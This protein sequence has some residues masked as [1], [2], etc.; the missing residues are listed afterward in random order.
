MNYIYPV[1]FIEIA[2]DGEL[3]ATEL[4]GLASWTLNDQF[5]VDGL[6]TAFMDLTQYSFDGW[7]SLK[8]TPPT[9]RNPQ[10]ISLAGGTLKSAD[11]KS[12]ITLTTANAASNN[13]EGVSWEQSGTYVLN[14]ILASGVTFSINVSTTYS[15]KP[16]GKSGSEKT[17][18]SFKDTKNSSN[19]SDDISISYAKTA[20]WSEGASFSRASGNENYSYIG[21]KISISLSDTWL[22][23]L[24]FSNSATVSG[25][26]TYGPTN[27]SI[28]DDNSGILISFSV[29]SNT[30]QVAGSSGE[31]VKFTNLVIEDQKTKITTPSVDW[32]FSY[33][34][35][36]ADVSLIGTDGPGVTAEQLLPFVLE[37]ASD[38]P[39]SIILKQAS[40]AAASAG[41]DSVTGSNFDDSIDGGAGADSINAGT[42]DDRIYAGLGDTID[43]GSGTDT[44]DFS[45]LVDANG[46]P[47]SYNLFNRNGVYTV[48][49]TPT[50]LV[51]TDLASKQ[52][53]NFN[54]VENFIFNG[55][56][57]PA[58]NLLAPRSRNVSG[59]ELLW[60][61]SADD[62]NVD[63]ELPLEM[64][65]DFVLQN[66]PLT[67]YVDLSFFKSD[68][69]SSSK[70]PLYDPDKGTYSFSFTSSAAN[71][72]VSTFTYAETNVPESGTG[73]SLTTA[74]G[75]SNATKGITFSGSQKYAETRTTNNNSGTYNSGVNLGYTNT[76]GT[77]RDTTDD[78]ALTFKFSET[79]A[80]SA[81]SAGYKQQGTG[82][83]NIGLVQGFGL[84]MT[85]DGLVSYNEAGTDFTDNK[86]VAFTTT[87][88]N[89]TLSYKDPV[90]TQTSDNFTINFAGKIVYD[91][92][93]TQA[94]PGP[95]QIAT[96]TNI[97]TENFYGKLTTAKAV[98]DLAEYIDP[99]DPGRGAIF[100]LIQSSSGKVDIDLIDNVASYL[101][102]L[103]D[104][105][106]SAD[107]ILDAANALTIKQVD[108]EI[109]YL[110]AGADTVTGSVGND[111]IDGGS[112][113]DSI[114]AGK[115]DDLIYAGLRDVIDGGEGIDTV[116]LSTLINDKGGNYDYFDRS[117]NSGYTV[118]GTTS[119]LVFRDT[120]TGA[121]VKFNNVEQ[122]KF[123]DQTFSA[124]RMLTP[125]SIDIT[126][127]V[128]LRG[129]G[130]KVDPQDNLA[131]RAL[132]QGTE[133]FLSDFDGN[134]WPLHGTVDLSFFDKDNFSA[135]QNYNPDQGTF[136]FNF[137][138]T[139]ANGTASVFK[140]TET[141]A[142]NTA[143]GGSRTT[144][145][146]LS[147]AAA[148]ITFKGALN[149]SERYSTS[150]EVTTWN[151]KSTDWGFTYTNTQGTTDKLDDITSSFKF[152]IA[153]TGSE[154][155]PSPFFTETGTF[156]ANYSKA[157]LTLAASGTFINSE[158][159]TSGVRVE[160]NTLTFD[161][162]SLAYKN[163][164]SSQTEAN[165]SISF[166]GSIAYDNNGKTEPDQKIET[167][168]FT[169]K[170]FVAED[171]NGK[172]TTA[173]AK[174]DLSSEKYLSADYSL[175]FHNNQGQV[176]ESVVL[177]LTTMLGLEDN[178]DGSSAFDSILDAANAITLKRSG[179]TY[180]GSGSDTVTG[181]DKADT[182]DGGAGA[183]T[184]NMGA[185]DDLIYA[186]LGD[187]IDGGAG[188]DSVDFSRLLDA[189]GKALTYDL[190]NRNGVYTVSGTPTAL[191][192][193]DVASKQTI[194]VKNVEKF[195][196]GGVEVPADEFFAPNSQERSGNELLRGI[197][198][199]NPN[200]APD[201]AL[202]LGYRYVLSPQRVPFTNEID[203]SFFE[204]VDFIGKN[205][206]KTYDPDKGT[207]NFT[208]TNGSGSNLSTF[209]FAETTVPN[210]G[211]G[212]SRT[213]TYGLSNAAEGIT[214]TGSQGSVDTFRINNGIYSGTYKID[215]GFSFTDT[216]GTT[217]TTSDDLIIGFK[218]NDTG[219]WTS[220]AT[221][222][223]QEGT[224]SWTTNYA[225]Q[226][227]TLASS[228]TYIER[229][230]TAS[231]GPTGEKLTYTVTSTYT[232]YKLA[233]TNPD[234][235]KTADNFS[236]G[237]SGSLAYDL[238]GT[239]LDK[240][241]TGPRQIFTITNYTGE[242]AF[243]KL[244]TAKAELDLSK[245]IDPTTPNLPV[246]LKLHQSSAGKVD[247]E[248][249]GQVVSF[250][251]FFNDGETSTD[252]IW[253]AANVLTLKQGTYASTGAKADTITGSAGND[254][255]DGGTGADS[256]T[257]G[258]GDDLIYAGLG[259][260]IDG[261]LGTDT[262][263]LSTLGKYDF[264]NRSTS[265]G[266][267][268]TGTAA[269]LVFRD[270]GTNE[271]VK[272]NNVEQFK[273]GDETFLA[274]RMLDP[275]TIDVSGDQ[276]L[277][278]IGTTIEGL[279]PKSPLA[280]GI[281]YV[282]T[283][284]DN[285]MWPLYGEA[286]LQYFKNAKF[287]ALQNYD[288]DAGTFNFSFKS[289]ADVDK[290]SVFKF[291]E[292]AAART[293]TRES[294]A[295]T[296]QL[297]NSDL[298][299]SFKG[300]RSFTDSYSV[301]NGV[302]TGSTKRD[303]SFSY[304][305]TQATKVTTDDVTA[306]FKISVT[307]T[308][309]DKPGNEFYTNNGSFSVGYSNGKTGW[310]LVS[311]GTFIDSETLI[312]D[313]TRNTQVTN[314]TSY[315]LTYKNPD[316]KNTVDNATISF[317]GVVSADYDGSAKT[318]TFTVK[319]FKGDFDGGTITTAL[320]KIDISAA[321]YLGDDVVLRLF[322]SEDGKVD[323]SVGLYLS[324]LLGLEDN[325]DGPMADDSIVDYANAVTFKRSGEAHLGAG[326][327]TL[328]GSSGA[329]TVDGGTGADILTMGA[330]DDLIYAGLSD[331][332]DG[333][334]GNDTADL[335]RLLDTNGQP[336]P[337]SLYDRVNKYT[338]S[339]TPTALV[340]TDI[341]S[342]Q[343]IKFK[344]V[345]N[346][347]LKEGTFTAQQL[348]SPYTVSGDDLLWGIGADNPNLDKFSYL[349]MGLE[350]I[351]HEADTKEPVYPFYGDIDLGFFRGD[352]FTQTVFYNPDEGAHNFSFTSSAAN[353]S[354]STFTFKETT[355]PNLGIGGGQ[356][357][358][359]G[360][361][362][363]KA[364]INFT[365]STTGS[366]T[367]TA[368]NGGKSVVNKGEIT[369]TYSNTQGNASKA[370]DIAVSF[371]IG[372]SGTET[373]TASGYREL[374]NGN[375][376]VN[377]ANSGWSIVA[378]GTFTDTETRDTDRTVTADKSLVTITNY[379]FS[380]TNP[381]VGST[382]KDNFNISF[383]G[384]IAEDYIGTGTASSP[385]PTQILTLTNLS[386]DFAEASITTA[387]AVL[388]LSDRFEDALIVKT[389]SNNEGQVD[390][391][392]VNYLSSL[393]GLDN[394]ADGDDPNDS[395][396]DFANVVT[397][398]IAGSGHLGAGNDTVNGSAGNDEIDG[399][400]DADSIMAG[401]GDD[402]IYAGLGDFID[403]G[404][405][406]DTVDLSTLS[407][408]VDGTYDFFTRNSE[409]GYT[410]AGT[411]SALVFRDT[412]TGATVKFNN[413]EQFKLGEKTFS[414]GRM[415]DPS[416]FDISASNLL[417][418]TLSI[419][420]HPR[421][422]V[423][424]RG[425][426]TGV[427][428]LLD[429]IS[430]LTA[431]VDLDSFLQ[432]DFAETVNYN[433]ASGTYAFKFTSVPV[434]NK[435]LTFKF[436]ETSTAYSEKGGSRTTTYDLNN[437]A[438]GIKFTG[439]A[440]YA[441]TFTATSSNWAGSK[442][443]TYTDTQTTSATTDDV[444][445]SFKFTESGTAG[446]GRFQD[447]GT[448]AVS[449]ANGGMALASSGSFAG[450]GTFG[451]D[452]QP[453]ARVDTITLGN[454]SLSQNIS[455]R[456]DNFTLSFSGSIAYD[457]LG[458]SLDP[459]ATDPRMVFTVS[460]MV[461]EDQSSKITTASAKLDLSSSI[462]DPT[463]AA[464][465]VLIKL[466]QNDA[467]S[468]DQS[469]LENIG[470]IFG[471]DNDGSS[472]FD[473]IWDAANGYTI[474]VSGSV[475]S[476]GGNDTIT[477]SSGTDS[478]DA[479]SGADLVN[480]GTGDD[481]IFGGDGADVLNGE[482][483]EDVID[484]GMGADNI[485]GGTGNDS[486]MGGLG[487]DTI[488]GGD[489]DDGISGG[490]GDVI[491]GGSGNDTWV[492]DYEEIGSITAVTGSMAAIT[493]TGK[494]ADTAASNFTIT[495][496]TV[497]AVVVGG[498]SYTDFNSLKGALLP[499]AV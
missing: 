84:T 36:S 91:A 280:K 90:A 158:T 62:S 216:Q 299:I 72:A 13:V 371:K 164:D 389:F 207:F 466:L 19:T 8:V 492:I 396:L 250:L 321:K 376:N 128:L 210:A 285:S 199:S 222:F 360:L 23:N 45:K 162:Y 369:Y 446:G 9:P 381:L 484:G 224:G 133:I 284:S 347:V 103:D 400:S 203:L 440:S 430:V 426:A 465:S 97:T 432:A 12:S 475:A 182:V 374:T 217:K 386:M 112:G 300:A 215:R 114:T 342:N 260:F 18:I 479:G 256:I 196:I 489:G 100:E 292:T 213:T 474:K 159:S 119:A 303:V 141:T 67:S 496:N 6:T 17:T 253:D 442:S 198:T 367:I 189:N 195:I 451:A 60:G 388:D 399:G 257:A 287:S 272:F 34:D 471:I 138:S 352:A 436:N 290:T 135:T 404:E 259:D 310:S 427:N 66:L 232:N 460:N 248:L 61:L 291:T 183:D 461:F 409:S 441:D 111:K 469:V 455:D 68:D 124:G 192:L 71:N 205:N 401:K 328:T 262:V 247:S 236:I 395:I 305:N 478:I 146:D 326:A 433:P 420:D 467:G 24:S 331:V 99:D 58:Q 3:T 406:F 137:N 63:N 464:G 480:A 494:R 150:K 123:G 329:D 14:M 264:L 104:G 59:N 44:V 356:T 498:V 437:A 139:A 254:I 149:W 160:A 340:L 226:G 343:T 49:G 156:V 105:P 453:T 171:V 184:L 361:T 362:N 391:S 25:S 294:R 348:L 227:L 313:V 476:G 229:M 77:A 263:D 228:G 220:K 30:G 443:F 424:E 22:E 41:A 346:F 419:P 363:T 377:Y 1:K 434:D 117:A 32:S 456:S 31:K 339:G 265:N 21:N 120:E 7:S 178:G 136:N 499:P 144:T 142:P 157:G 235:T 315:T 491:T 5:P 96:L 338:V 218:T 422:D 468:V 92:L 223:A 52:K 107:S 273:L 177:Y 4:I 435:T 302:T 241:A 325:G 42:G 39:N 447:S 445:I 353:G 47:I 127:N 211:S 38:A 383:K 408:P 234:T 307:G 57:I 481:F 85:L 206:T 54:N 179:E 482:T 194:T 414:A 121:T 221:G 314:L 110:G 323:E 43:G 364:G 11:S 390:E 51:L 359:F 416:S 131:P 274:G 155:A 293:A 197:G 122:F 125:T 270:T 166:N 407:R 493:I 448:F 266:Y 161:K 351:F 140:F 387:K 472:S 431:D 53:I 355:V 258:A 393:F 65:V 170:N 417:K 94:A 181:S 301:N 411:T 172:I 327:D 412:K 252:S 98:L 413:V 333:E 282:L 152:T 69:F 186:G 485:S 344:N 109:V 187:V 29:L 279:S 267:T 269:A 83:F 27:Y 78:V 425:T 336:L 86:T 380:Y 288:P 193:T 26:G 403:G 488:V 75:L 497:E 115:G 495:A 219:S 335:S 113:A 271:T 132:A 354:T 306:S 56:T 48:T 101:G 276:L 277:W 375:F 398:K 295:T 462:S 385:N 330:G 486:L 64:G 88:N 102:L 35:E 394:F 379:V 33:D 50:A 378:N 79:G 283:E 16:E 188:T 357:T 147:N 298:G 297:D 487:N 246:W 167:Q 483:G 190:Y 319:N 145:Y 251:G 449:Y 278:G 40:G 209:T 143:G 349:V 384:S 410:V 2:G 126:G 82:S 318:Q 317:T 148:G 454:Y 296:Y 365:G 176:D 15:D 345:E 237:F 397:M 55:Q 350:R 240:K 174:I 89:Y 457:L 490:A 450:S 106:S 444:I 10:N 175:L 423:M 275:S 463:D 28:K 37:L 320:A 93:G 341:A 332:I 180:A 309:S 163:P 249:I 334:A 81:G 370:D 202:A 261:G 242:D 337:Y 214:F 243:G 118:T 191:V 200:I 87:I 20:T 168:F 201:S 255:I 169:I 165:G 281:N 312:N 233:Y 452:G 230:T 76:Q 316:T 204:G 238:V 129:N 151:A 439:S 418:G 116:D 286:D 212:G 231:S 366:E 130:T 402:L 245:S 311:A 225:Q 308:E 392:I 428:S 470:D 153:N 154:N 46:Q 173:L 405:G 458:K 95:T 415:L 268:V 373:Y 477:G 358:S 438:E 108:D 80:W 289:N 322:H 382:V 74:Y 372:G 134:G 70:N 244:T 304:T 208:F 73:N 185:G 459:A 368:I 239:S 473:S 324:T 421:M 429:D